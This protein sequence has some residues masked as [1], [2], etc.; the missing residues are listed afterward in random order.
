MLSSLGRTLDAFLVDMQPT[1]EMCGVEARFAAGTRVAGANGRVIRGL[2]RRPHPR[3]LLS[4]KALRQWTKEE[5]LDVV[6]V[7]TA[8]AAAWARIARLSVP[9]VYFCHGLHWSGRQLREVPFRLIETSLA[10]RNAGVIVINEEDENWFRNRSVVTP[11]LR[12]KNGVGVPIERFPS[13][14][15][16]G[17]MRELLWM[18]E[19][20]PRKE[21]ERALDV[22]LALRSR[23]VSASLTMAGEGPLR[24]DV[25]ARARDLGLKEDI[26]FPGRVDPGAALREADGLLHTARWEGLARVLLEAAAV[27][28]PAFGFD[29][30]GVR[31]AP[32]VTAVP[33]GDEQALAEAL[34]D[35][36]GSAYVS[37]SRSELSVEYAANEIATFVKDVH[38]NYLG[39]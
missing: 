37:P 33:F 32:G 31:D 12:L 39:E 10:S 25:E 18:G 30:K 4:V 38:R 15:S 23:G 19:F 14:G 21:P 20:S 17:R 28:T 29:V 2:T 24:A 16:S 8:T 36:S 13:N 34:L 7:S 3:N 35:W 6:L 11:V 22:M 9:V 26:R 5:E 27:G 1:W